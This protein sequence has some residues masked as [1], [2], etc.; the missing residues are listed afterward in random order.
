MVPVFFHV[1]PSEVG[2]QTGTFGGGFAELVSK[3]QMEIERVQSW[4]AALKKVAKVSGFVY[5]D[6]QF[7]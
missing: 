7:E 2:N 4:K 3:H 6:P 5:P 1:K